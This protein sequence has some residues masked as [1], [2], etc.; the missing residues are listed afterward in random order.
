MR[1]EEGKRSGL[2]RD[3]RPEKDDK[4]RLYYMKK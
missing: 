1:R 2:R 3:S 4:V